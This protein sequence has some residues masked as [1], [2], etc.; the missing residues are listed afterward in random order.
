MCV[1]VCARTRACV[2]VFWRACVRR[3]EGYSTHFIF[4]S[5]F[6]MYLY[7]LCN[8]Q[9]VHL[10]IL[11]A[12]RHGEAHYCMATP[13]PTP[14][15]SPF[16]HVRARIP[17]PQTSPHTGFASLFPVVPTLVT[18]GFASQAAGYAIDCQVFTPADAPPACQDAHSQVGF[19]FFEKRV[20]VCVCVCAFMCV[21][22]L[23][24]MRTHGSVI[25]VC[26]E[27][28]ECVHSCVCMA[29]LWGTHSAACQEECLGSCPHPSPRQPHTYMIEFEFQH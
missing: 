27:K 19:R 25:T 2:C 4:Y 3:G 1:C 22:G 10:H 15:L 20:C 18:N 5:V 7:N 9:G 11:C 8:A 26:L 28:H 24:W 17:N 21:R 16:P 12:V 23:L 6:T 13:S 29:T 14:A